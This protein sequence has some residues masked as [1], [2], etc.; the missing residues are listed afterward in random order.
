MIVD[1]FLEIGIPD[2][3]FCMHDFAVDHR[4]AFAVGTAQVE[5]DTAA[6]KIAAEF[7]RDLFLRSGIGVSAGFDLKFTAVNAFTHNLI[8]EGARAVRL[9]GLGDCV[10]NDFAAGDDDL[11]AAL[12]PQQGLD[13]AFNDADVFFIVA[14]AVLENTGLVNGGVALVS[15]NADNEVLAVFLGSFTHF[16]ANDRKRGKLRVEFCFNFKIHI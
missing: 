12:D 10:V 5:T 16:A 15:F 6:L 13:D 2:H 8:V 7:D 3:L 9:V 1:I 14:G 4:R 11:V